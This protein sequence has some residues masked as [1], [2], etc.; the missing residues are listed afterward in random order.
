MKKAILLIFALATSTLAI[1]AQ[2]TSPQHTIEVEGNSEIMIVPDE[3]SIHVS[4]QKKAMTVAE[5]TKLLNADTKKI[6]DAFKKSGLDH[7]LTAN[8]YYV[9]VN[10]IYQK[11]SAKDSG[12]VA[13]Q[14]LKITVKD[15]EKQLPKAVELVNTSGGDHSVNVNFSI[16]KAKE[17]SYK[18]QLLELALK[19][20]QEKAKKIAEVM[21][22][23]DLKVQKVQYAS[24]QAIPRN[25]MM[26]TSAMAFDA[27]ESREAPSFIPEEQ[28]I[29][30]RVL[31]T[32]VFVP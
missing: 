1:Q 10:R 9:N 2:S 19:D 4:V 3:G 18:E 20:A 7:E 5:A 26:K 30:D 31:V 27:M 15:I 24:N 22:L 25:Y 8:N 32:F 23:K 17:K 11:G 14:N 21:D 12:F 29:S 13:S 28:T 16:S 6:I